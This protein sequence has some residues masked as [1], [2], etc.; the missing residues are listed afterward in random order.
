MTIIERE[1][2]GVAPRLDEAQG[3]IVELS[4]RLETGLAF[5]LVDGPVASGK[6]ELVG[7]YSFPCFS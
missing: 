3:L 2:A 6:T 5:L 7:N 1:R 4:Q